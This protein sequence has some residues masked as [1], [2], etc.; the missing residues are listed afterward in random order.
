MTSTSIVYLDV[1]L[2]TVNH[3]NP[4]ETGINLRIPYTYV[5]WLL[6]EVMTTEIAHYS[7]DRSNMFLQ[8]SASSR[9]T[10]N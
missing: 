1:Q 7:V 10:L 2:K 8:L 5:D 6:Y 3:F 4:L 9:P